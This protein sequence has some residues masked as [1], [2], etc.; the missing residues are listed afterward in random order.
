[1]KTIK[2]ILIA[3]AGAAATL[4]LL[5]LGAT[6]H[7]GGEPLG[8]FRRSLYLLLLPAELIAE[9]VGSFESFLIVGFLQFFVP[10][11]LALLT[12]RLIHA[13]KRDV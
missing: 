1:M 5:W 7:F 3:T 8:G 11:L 10:Y 13:S 2:I 9:S 4:A 6:G 12:W